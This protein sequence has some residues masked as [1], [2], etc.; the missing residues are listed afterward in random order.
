LAEKD[1]L[2]NLVFKHCISLAKLILGLINICSSL[3]K[4]DFRSD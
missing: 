3:A 4:F 1:G 2:Y